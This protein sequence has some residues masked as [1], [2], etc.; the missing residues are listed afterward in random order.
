MSKHEQGP[1]RLSP[2]GRY[3]YT[4]ERT[5]NEGAPVLAWMGLNPSTADASQLDPTLRRV[6][7]FSQIWG[8]GGFVMLN[9]FAFRATKPED[10]LAAKEPIGAWND[11]MILLTLARTDVHTLVVCWGSHGA[12]RGR[13]VQMAELCRNQAEGGRGVNVHCLGTTNG[14]QPKHPLYLPK[15]TMFEPWDYDWHLRVRAG[16]A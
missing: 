13:D 6:M 1:A 5:W 2:D 12:H 11:R 7:D 14:G 15:I 16:A 10:M 4:L 9:M 8:Y 3:R